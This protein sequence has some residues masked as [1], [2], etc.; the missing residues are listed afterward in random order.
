MEK[1]NQQIAF[2]LEMDK[3][4]SILRRSYLTH[5]ERR[6]NSAEH[7]WHIALAALVMQVATRLSIVDSKT[8]L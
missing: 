5:N 7:S 1:L 3:L 8:G 6:E 4:K 2:I